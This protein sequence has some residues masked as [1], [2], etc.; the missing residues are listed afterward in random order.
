MRNSIG[1]CSM[2]KARNAIRRRCIAATSHATNALRS[3]SRKASAMSALSHSALHVSLPCKPARDPRPS[4]AR[5]ESS[6]SPP[7]HVQSQPHS[8]RSAQMR[9]VFAMLRPILVTPASL[10]PSA[11]PPQRACG[12]PPSHSSVHPT[13]SRPTG[14]RARAASHVVAMC[15]RSVAACAGSP[16]AEPAC[17]GA[18]QRQVAAT[19]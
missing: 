18:L 7:L 11:P 19:V 10:Q 5:A 13:V 16:H 9:R 15:G 14:A 12:A 4:A 1:C 17:T 6:A 2:E 3:A 8:D